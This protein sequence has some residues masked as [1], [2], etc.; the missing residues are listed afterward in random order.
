MN[1][2]DIE[3]DGGHLTGSQTRCT[4][5]AAEESNTTDNTTDQTRLERLRA[6]LRGILPNAVVGPEIDT[7]HLRDQNYRW[8]D[9]CRGGRQRIRPLY[10]LRPVI[11]PTRD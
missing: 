8:L 4:A 3:M 2:S 6:W 5:A 11:Q 10:H 1:F 9:T 7:E